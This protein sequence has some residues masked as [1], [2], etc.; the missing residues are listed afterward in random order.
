M[1]L[2][3]TMVILNY[4][5]IGYAFKFPIYTTSQGDNGWGLGITLGLFGVA[6]IASY[7]NLK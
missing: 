6:N 3:E 7:W 2:S 1:S 4:V 5:Y